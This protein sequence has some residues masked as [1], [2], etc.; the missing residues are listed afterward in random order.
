MAK[1]R[2][3]GEGSVPRQRKDGR[4]QSEYSYYDKDGNLARGTITAPTQTECVKKLQAALHKI[5]V[6]TYTQ[7][8]KITFETW[9]M[10]WYRLYGEP[11]WKS[12][13]TRVVHLTNIK[14]H[15]IPAFG[16]ILLQKIQPP[17]LQAFFN[18][19]TN[20]GYSTSTIHK[21]KE[22]L[23][24]CMKKAHDLGMIA[25][26]PCDKIEL[27]SIRKDEVEH[28]NHDEMQETLDALP[29]T[30]YGRACALILL[31]G[32]RKAECA[33][34]QWGDVDFDNN[35]IQVR[36][37]AC[38]GKVVH[39][40]LMSDHQELIIQLAKTKK[41]FREIPLIPQA[42][43]ILRDQRNGQMKQYLKAGNFWTCS[44]AGEK[45]C[46]VFTTGIGTVL[47]MGNALRTLEKTLKTAEIH[48]VTLHPLRHSALTEINKNGID[49]KT[50][51]EIAGHSK[52]AFTLQ[53]YCHSDIEAKRKGM[54]SLE[55]L[56][57]EQGD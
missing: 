30:T 25:A 3:N 11:C 41:G 13:R 27:P 43:Q 28:L 20:E 24:G 36:R 23:N 17:R 37:T 52:V 5:N 45:D 9:I 49:S 22:P 55:G 18:S 6:G 51:S 38:Y 48:R 31:T 10:D 4:W 35:V 16:K 53:T 21:I 44:K 15:L 42:A 34:L 40:G 54:K 1:R 39:D 29:N 8:D 56:F 57:V 33:G 32:L 7:P 2:A 46:W 14:K 19:L 50:L 12:Q 26:N 47:E